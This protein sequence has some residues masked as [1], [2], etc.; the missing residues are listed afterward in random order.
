[1]TEAPETAAV[2]EEYETPAPE[3]ELQLSVGPETYRDLETAREAP[4]AEM[5]LPTTF[6]GQRVGAPE[7]E[8]MA[9]RRRRTT[10]KLLSWLSSTQDHRSLTR[11]CCACDNLQLPQPQSRL[12]RFPRRSRNRR[13]SA[14]SNT[15]F[16]QS[17][18]HRR[19]VY[20]RRGPKERTSLRSRSFSDGELAGLRCRRTW[21]CAE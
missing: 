6:L 9:E 13:G 7:T 11:K 1:L 4:S 18:N 20:P 5:F 19:V 3:E 21:T 12:R 15:K 17:S 16:P 2:P 8:A 10:G 14:N